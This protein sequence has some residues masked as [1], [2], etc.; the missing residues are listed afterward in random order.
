MSDEKQP[1]DE[2]VDDTRPV[3]EAGP[4]EPAHIHFLVPAS[5]QSEE[6]DPVPKARRYMI[7][8]V[9]P[10]IEAARRGEVLEGRK[11]WVKEIVKGNPKKGYK[12]EFKLRNSAV[13]VENEVKTF[14]APTLE[15]VAVNLE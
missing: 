7:R 10:Q 8:G 13:I 1:P 6:D 11:G 5:E 3:D 12:Y 14:K 15:E 2:G 9:E 4:P